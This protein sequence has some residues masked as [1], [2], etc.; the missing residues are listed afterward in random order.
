MAIQSYDTRSGN[1]MSRLP[2]ERMCLFQAFRN[3]HGGLAGLHLPHDVGLF[4]RQ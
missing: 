2:K 4:T 1:D 3:A